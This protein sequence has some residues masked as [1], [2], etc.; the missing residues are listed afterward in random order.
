MGK[1]NFRNIPLETHHKIDLMGVDTFKVGA[2]VE[3]PN[4]DIAQGK[5]NYIGIKMISGELVFSSE[6]IPKPRQRRP[7]TNWN[8]RGKIVKRPDLPK[9]HRSYSWYSPNFGDYSKG[10]HLC[11]RDGYFIVQEF[12]PP[13]RIPLSIEVL[14]SR[15]ESSSVFKVVVDEALSKT[16]V[17]L[18]DKL[19]FDINLLQENIGTYDVIP[20]G[21][22]VEDYLVRTHVNWEILPPGEAGDRILQR[23]IAEAEPDPRKQMAIFERQKFI[24]GLSPK[25][26][27]IGT[28]GFQRY[29]GYLFSDNLVVFENVEY[30][31]A[32]YIM[33]DDWKELSQKSRIE[34][35][36][37]ERNFIRIVHT[38]RWQWRV[39]EE[40]LQ[41]IKK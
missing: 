35:L 32:L 3:L 17:D 15:K 26:R 1:I 23:V 16:D 6:I 2:I 19:L 38:K 7:Y 18:D 22:T 21:E 9:E 5:Y 31:N 27:I 34:L 39:R 11:S 33:F 41:H 37:S 8:A 36:A 28:S 30:G 12:Y 13:R 14:P 29:V 40:I 20:D 24:E 10:E 4:E 25:R